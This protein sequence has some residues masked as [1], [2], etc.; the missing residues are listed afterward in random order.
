MKGYDWP[1]ML[2]YGLFSK[3]RFA[4]RTHVVDLFLFR[5]IHVV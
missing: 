5:V 1:F 3:N 2:F 4:L